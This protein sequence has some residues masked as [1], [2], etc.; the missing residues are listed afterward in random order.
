[1]SKASRARPRTRATPEMR[2]RQRA[3]AKARWAD[4]IA[5]AKL[6][7]A[8]RSPASRA[9]MSEAS[10]ARWADPTARENLIAKFRASYADPAVRQKR[11]SAIKERWADPSV[12][13]K[14]IAGMRATTKRRRKRDA[15]DGETGLARRN[16]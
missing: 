3:I 11:A 9:K 1:L 8:I 2:E 6:R 4:P 7:A 13:E 10:R 16:R 12:R 5:G 14:I 15:A